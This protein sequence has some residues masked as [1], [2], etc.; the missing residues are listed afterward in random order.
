[1][2]KI[3]SQMYRNISIH[4]LHEESDGKIGIVQSG[5]D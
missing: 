3:D 4:A 5:V 1:M 2:S